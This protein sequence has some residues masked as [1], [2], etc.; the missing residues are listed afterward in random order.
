MENHDIYQDPLVSRY[1][2]EEMQKLFSDNFKYKTW[3]KCWTALAESQMELGVKQINKDMV[4]EMR[5]ASEKEIDY[6][7]VRK[8]EKEIRHDVM[9][10]VFEF[11]T[12]CPNAKGII[13]LGATSQFVVCNTDLI[14]MRGALKIIRLQLLKT[15]KNMSDFAEKHKET[16]TLG[17]THYQPAQPDRKSVV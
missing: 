6:D 14:Q 8:K 12:K 4:E 11:G 1:T 5:S 16:A 15:I 2:D 10:H 3:R 13:H 17:Y 9:A 7:L